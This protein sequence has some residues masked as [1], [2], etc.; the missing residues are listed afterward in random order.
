VDISWLTLVPWLASAKVRD[1][2]EPIIPGDRQAPTNKNF[3]ENFKAQAWWNVARMFYRTWQV[4]QGEAEHPPD[5]LISINSATIPKATLVK[6]TAELCQAT[7]GQ[8]TRLKLVIDKAPEG[9]KSPNLADGLVMGR[10]PARPVRVS[11]VAP[12]GALGP[13]V[14]YS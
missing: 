5:R 9:A 3:F 6:L 4:R 1:P 2:G 11:G 7:M 13:K 8:S 10:F 14:F 12:L